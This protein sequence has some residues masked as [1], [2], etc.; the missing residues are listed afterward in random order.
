MILETLNRW[1][2]SFGGRSP[3]SEPSLE[4]AAFLENTLS[5]D[6]TL[7]EEELDVGPIIA[8][9]TGDCAAGF[10]VMHDVHFKAGEPVEVSGNAELIA[11]LR[12][13]GE[14]TV[15]D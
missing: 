12:G 7:N 2:S 3:F 4:G 8:T 10:V 5:E 14:F 11:K 9:Y 13:N 6:E 1:R 15:A